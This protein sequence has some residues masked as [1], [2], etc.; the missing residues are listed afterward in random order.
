MD[1]DVGHM[2]AVTARTDLQLMH[3][4]IEFH[5]STIL[6]QL[7]PKRQMW[8]IMFIGLIPRP[9]FIWQLP[10]VISRSNFVVGPMTVMLMEQTHSKWQPIVLR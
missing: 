1:T 7:M 2:Y 8:I 6:W 3:D 10:L 5:S 4:A 9:Y